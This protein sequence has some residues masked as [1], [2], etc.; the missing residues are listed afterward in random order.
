[1][2]HTRYIDDVG[3]IV[4]VRMGSVDVLKICCHR[5]AGVQFVNQLSAPLGK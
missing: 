5:L 1:M 2:I 3:E 4:A